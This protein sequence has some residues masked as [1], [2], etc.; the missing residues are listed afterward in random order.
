MFKKI[1]SGE[2]EFHETDW[3]GVSSQAKD[4]I[5]A[6][7]TVDPAR[8]LTASQ[9]LYHPWILAAG[10]SS[11]PSRAASPK[12]SGVTPKT[13]SVTTPTVGSNVHKKKDKD[14]KKTL[15][16]K[17]KAAFGGGGGSGAGPKPI[18]S[19]PQPVLR[20]SSQ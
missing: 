16:R 19:R 1:V 2:F 6:L 17:L 15:P 3:S 4:F 8:R 5:K 10:S 14:K 11:K 9:A 12:P 13:S 18:V 7:L 20:D